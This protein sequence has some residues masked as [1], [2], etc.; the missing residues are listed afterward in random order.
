ML[1][2]VILENCGGCDSVAKVEDFLS[3]P[4]KLY[5]RGVLHGD[6]KRQNI[7]CRTNG[8]FVLVDF[9]RSEIVALEVEMKAEVEKAIYKFTGH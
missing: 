5:A 9:G 2:I 3:L 4:E 1:D 6:V 7:V 8:S